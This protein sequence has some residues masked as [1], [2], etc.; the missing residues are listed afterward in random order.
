MS[1]RS[2]TCSLSVSSWHTVA[3]D[4]A[5]DR[6]VRITDNATNNLSENATTYQAR[7]CPCVWDSN[8]PDFYCVE[9][10]GDL[11]RV[12]RGARERYSSGDNP[13]VCLKSAPTQDFIRSVWPV[14]PLSF[15]ALILS[16]L[17]TRPGRNALKYFFSFCFRRLN[18]RLVSRIYRREMMWLERARAAVQ[19][20]REANAAENGEEIGPPSSYLL[21][22]E[23]FETNKMRERR[24]Q[25]RGQDMYALNSGNESDNDNEE[26]VASVA[27]SEGDAFAF[28]GT[29]KEKTP[30]EL[31]V[32]RDDEQFLDD[33]VTC[34]IC[35]LEIEDGD[36]IGVLPCDH[37]FHVDCLK[38]WILKRN[39]CPLC[40]TKKIAEPQYDHNNDENGDTAEEG[41]D[42]GNDDNDGE[43]INPSPSRFRTVT[44]RVRSTR[45]RVVERFHR[46][47]NNNTVQISN[48]TS[49]LHVDA[50]TTEEAII[51]RRLR[52]PRRYTE[53]NRFM[54]W[55]GLD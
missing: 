52:S 28:N 48:G 49:I 12:N 29:E 32:S 43:I 18:N 15:G 26:L 41:S 55:L 14:I 13:I 16:L 11:C 3:F 44:A 39:S 10:T 31:N 25:K 19:T 46:Y 50:I 35:I 7:I 54:V 20:Q 37:Y 27:N 21:K 4:E 8:L 24:I 53:S 2:V 22:T 6:Y 38:P 42:G 1:F 40:Q 45:N 17:V 5:A 23:T 34:T 30:E 33:G 51:H 47:N 36:R 9:G